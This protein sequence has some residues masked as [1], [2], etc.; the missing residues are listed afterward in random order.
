[1][2]DNEIEDHWLTQLTTDL[3]NIGVLFVYG[4]YF[5]VGKS[6]PVEVS[7]ITLLILFGQAVFLSLFETI[8]KRD[9]WRSYDDTRRSPGAGFIGD[10]VHRLVGCS[11][12]TLRVV[13]LSLQSRHKTFGKP[14]KFQSSFRI[15]F[16]VPG[17]HSPIS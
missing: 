1:M 3:L 11:S 13:S 2:K 6:P 14:G 10:P 5:L 16:E 12:L 4:S 17:V 9:S 7:L 15:N 8:R